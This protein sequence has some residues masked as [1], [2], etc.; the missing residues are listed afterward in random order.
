MA[1]SFQA[2]ARAF[3]GY[4]MMGVAKSALESIIRYLALELGKG[5]IRINAIS[6][7]PVDTLAAYGEILAVSS[8]P[9]AIANMRGNLIRD[10]IAAADRAVA[11]NSET[12]SPEWLQA[13]ERQLRQTFAARCAIEETVS[14]EDIAG[15]ALFLG[16]RLST[17]ITGQVIHVDAG[18]SSS[19][20]I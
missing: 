17:K 9:D 3:P 10:V 18:L 20:I 7:G 19:L 1:M 15:C 13:A 2:A 14:K 16:S 5:R 6:P 12:R 11:G 4:G 8:D